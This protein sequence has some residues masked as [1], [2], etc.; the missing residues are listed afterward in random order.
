M[1]VGGLAGSVAVGTLLTP[2]G[3]SGSGYT[4][5]EAGAPPCPAPPHLASPGFAP[6]CS[7]AAYHAPIMLIS[8]C[9]GVLSCCCCGAALLGAALRRCGAVRCA[10]LLAAPDVVN[11]RRS[12]RHKRLIPPGPRRQRRP[13]GGATQGRRPGPQ[14]TNLGL[15]SLRG[16]RQASGAGWL[17]AVRGE[18]RVAYRG[19]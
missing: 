8:L 13:C 5:T 15:R 4:H 9:C 6:P 7:S 3:K 16:R 17:A 18:G 19:R 2:V 1:G 14:G 12:G 10:A 11:Y